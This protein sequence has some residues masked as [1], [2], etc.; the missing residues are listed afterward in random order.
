MKYET[1]IAAIALLAAGC[2]AVA[3]SE[4]TPQ[5]L[6]ELGTTLTPWGAVKAGNKDGTIPAFEGRV[7]IPA[8]YDPKNPG[9]RPDPYINEKIQ[10]SITAA[11][12]AQ[13]QDKLSPGVRAML[14]K[15][16]TFRVDVYPS[17]RN[18]VYPKWVLDN[19][20]K[21]ATACKS[22]DNNLTLE[23]CYAGIPFPIPKTGSE[24]MWNHVVKY[25]GPEAWKARFQSFAVDSAGNVTMQGDNIATVTTPWYD[26][27]R[28]EPNPVG[29]DFFN[30]R[31][32]TVGPA[33]KAGESLLI[34]ESTKM[35]AGG[36]RIWQYLP[37]QRR[38]KMSPDL[39]YDTPMPQGGGAMTM[40]DVRA[41]AGALD[42]FDFKLVGKREMY[43]PYNNYKMQ[44]GGT[45]AN[46]QRLTPKHF[47]PDCVRW[48]LHRVWEVD[49]KP[50]EGVRH[51]YSRRTMY[52]DEDHQGAG[53][54][55][56]YD[57]AGTIYRVSIAFSYPYYEAEAMSVDQFA[58]FDL[59]TGAYAESVTSTE[60]GGWVLVPRPPGSYYTPDSMAAN[61]VR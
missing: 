12:M 60:H 10:F 52:F 27:T 59:A 3:H 13:Y 14:Q 53:M 33:R 25:N 31:H 32:D 34:L 29:T 45:C 50:K 37:G 42:R 7:A 44:A 28:T 9:V 4:A 56:G 51:L 39:S 55:D 20:V 11:N 8:S 2:T 38:V 36:T 18:M 58:T 46:A 16:P 6:K 48:E 41:F 35:G 1:R 19:T 47:N 49:S 57:S 61:G 30:Y 5:E 23:G 17:H 15:Y 40:D 26:K 24:V 43:I 54:S 21:N 22:I